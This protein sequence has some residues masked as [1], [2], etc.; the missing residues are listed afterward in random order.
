MKYMAPK[1]RGTHS[2]LLL[3]K[4]RCVPSRASCMA[5][6][7]GGRWGRAGRER[8]QSPFTA[9][10]PLAPE[11]K[12]SPPPASPSWAIWFPAR[13]GRRGHAVRVQ[14]PEAVG[15]VMAGRFPLMQCPT[16]ASLRG[17]WTRKTRWVQEPQVERTHWATSLWSNSRMLEPGFAKQGCGWQRHTDSKDKQP[18]GQ[19]ER[20]FF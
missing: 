11:H 2:F 8:G 18:P 20:Q 4:N 16:G 13:I 6:G 19:L 3:E 14:T 17:P 1:F 15:G 12:V 5:G 9:C 10:W 7:S